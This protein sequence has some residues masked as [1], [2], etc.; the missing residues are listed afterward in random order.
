MA[1]PTI[2]RDPDTCTTR[3]LSPE[4]WEFLDACVTDNRLTEADCDYLTDHLMAT[5][6]GTV[7]GC[8]AAPL[9]V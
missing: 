8:G 7:I 2:L 5:A 1:T 6:A 9:A 3:R 4:V